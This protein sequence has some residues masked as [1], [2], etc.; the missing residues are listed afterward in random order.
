MLRTSSYLVGM[1]GIRYELKI[2]NIVHNVC[3]NFLLNFSH[4]LTLLNFLV[5]TFL[6]L[7]RTSSQINLYRH[8]KQ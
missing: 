6:H 8:I 3:T 4:I 7:C 5:L 1:L 2:C